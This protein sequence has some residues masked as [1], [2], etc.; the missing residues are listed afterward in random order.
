MGTHPLLKHSSPSRTALSAPHTLLH[1]RSHYPTLTDYALHTILFLA[2][3]A[4]QA[5][6]ADEASYKKHP[7][8]LVSGASEFNGTYEP[9]MEGAYEKRPD[10]RRKDGSGFISYS[11]YHSPVW[12]MWTLTLKGNARA[13]PYYICNSKSKTPPVKGSWKKVHAKGKRPQVV[14]QVMVK[15]QV[16]EL[17][18]P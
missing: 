12:I 11:G 9:F 16:V 18:K 13:Y 6:E 15:P 10:Y 8:V 14:V 2:A 5:V 17:C 4:W 3:L 1:Y 7:N